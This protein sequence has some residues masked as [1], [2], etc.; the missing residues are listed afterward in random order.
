MFITTFTIKQRI[1]NSVGALKKDIELGGWGG[2]NTFSFP[3]WNI[4]K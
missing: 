2:G 4:K 3:L 1:N